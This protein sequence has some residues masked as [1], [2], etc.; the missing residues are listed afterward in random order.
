MKTLRPASEPEVV[1]QF[2]RGELESVR[3]GAKILRCLGELGQPVSLLNAPNL[4]DPE[5]N[6]L[7][8]VL[9]GRF[10]GYGENREMF[11]RFP[12]RLDWS[13]VRFEEGDLDRV[14]YLRY[15]YWDELS[16]GTHHAADAARSVRAG[17]EVY[18]VSNRPFLDGERFL[19]QGGGFPPLILVSDGSRHTVLE[20]NSRLTV[21]GLAPEYF[22]GTVCY[23]GHC[24]VSEL[25]KWNP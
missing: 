18:G 22:P 5:Q 13:L 2:L 3:F 12:E 7:R 21:Y 19:R 6:R 9:L 23:L 11:E 16:G 25:T 4:S 24:S 10:R 20:G 14:E 17:V 8:S 1:L 15:C